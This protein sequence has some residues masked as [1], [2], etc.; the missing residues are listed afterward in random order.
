MSQE[1]YKISKS[2][3]LKYDQCPKA[4]FLYKKFPYLRDPISK[5]KQFTFN[6]GHEVGHL[7]QQLFPGGIDA[8]LNAKGAQEVANN[9]QQLLQNKITT[10]YEATFVFN[11]VLIMVDIL[12]FDGEKWNAYE[13][14]SS[15]KVS[16][17]YVK[18]ACLQYYV[19]KNALPLFSNLY[20][21][22]LNGDYVLGEE[23][24]LNKLFKKRNISADAEKNLDF[25]THKVSEIN[26]MLE[27]NVTPEIAI[28]KHCF[29]P[30]ACD[31]TGTCWKNISNEKSVFKI[32][33]SDRDT[34]FNWYQ[35]GKDTVD[36]VDITGDIKPHIKIQIECIKENKEYFNSEEIK[37]LLKKIGINS[38]FMDMEVWSPAVPKYKGHKPFEQLPFLF[39]VCSRKN[40]ELN[41]Y[42][43]LIPEGSNDIKAF[44]VALI[45]AMEKFDNVV[46][47]DKNLELQV[48][49]KIESL[50]PEFSRDL[51]SIRKKIIDLSDLVQNFFYYNPKFNGNFSLKAIADIL[52]ETADYNK[53][54]I[55]S[56]I[57]AMYKYEALSNEPNPI[58]KE[59]YKQQLIDYCNLDTLTCLKFYEYLLEKIKEQE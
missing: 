20:L 30:Y 34:L 29:S 11:S 19:L 25:F 51:N 13:V 50:Y 54:E 41:Y 9:T 40:G 38:C 3:F 36:K 42:H 31:F 1:L 28:G 17:V 37:K 48:I 32:G 46:V 43:H 27:K 16:E 8:S 24:E 14:K 26:L 21:V 33:K 12:Y 22:T 44:T 35:S 52:D 4:F 18:D 59:T 23:L 5:E 6:R 15:L 49:A 57:T 47:Y 56:G 53:L 10:I 45:Y 55:Q 58:I 2:G 7:A 39:S